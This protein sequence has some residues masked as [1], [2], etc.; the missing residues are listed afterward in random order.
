[1]V[2]LFFD[3]SKGD[4]KLYPFITKTL[5]KF[6]QNLQ[7]FSLGAASKGKPSTRTKWSFGYGNSVPGYNTYFPIIALFWMYVPDVCALVRIFCS[8]KRIRCYYPFLQ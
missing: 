5:H 7:R 6:Y 4:Y 3:K 1:M 2:K 8:L